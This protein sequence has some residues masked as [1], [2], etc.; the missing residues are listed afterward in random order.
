MFTPYPPTEL[1]HSRRP[2]QRQRVVLTHEQRAEHVIQLTYTYAIFHTPE[3]CADVMDLEYWIYR[4]SDTNTA[5]LDI[6]RQLTH[7]ITVNGMVKTILIPGS[8][9][10]IGFCFQP[11]IDDEHVIPLHNTR[12]PT[13]KPVFLFVPQICG[14]TVVERNRRSPVLVSDHVKKWKL[15]VSDKVINAHFAREEE[16]EEDVDCAICTESQ[17]QRRLTRMGCGHEYCVDCLCALVS[18]NKDKTTTLGCPMCRSQIK[19]VSTNSTET[20]TKLMMFITE[21]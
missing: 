18:T 4:L 11:E 14:R 3:Y 12:M 1:Q 7:M 17:T 9:H 2:F 10:T 8:I 6:L 21:L 13:N 15:A 5:S 20:Y 19:K 16:M